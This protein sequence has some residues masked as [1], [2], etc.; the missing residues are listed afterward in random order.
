MQ[1]TGIIPLK[2]LVQLYVVTLVKGVVN[3]AFAQ[4]GVVFNRGS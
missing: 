2:V 3:A 1:L 4:A